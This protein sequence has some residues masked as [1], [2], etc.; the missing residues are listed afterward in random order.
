M[1]TPQ[2]KV[3]L[4]D[5]G[6]ASV[7]PSG[8]TGGAFWGLTPGYAAPEQERGE[9]TTTQTDLYNL[10]VTLSCLLAGQHSPEN[11]T[12][13]PFTP[14]ETI[15]PAA[16]RSL[17]TQMTEQDKNLRPGTAK[18]IGMR[19][20][21]ILTELQGRPC[22]NEQIRH[23]LAS[24][25]ATYRAS[26]KLET[27]YQ[28]QT[29]WYQFRL[30]TKQRQRLDVPAKITCIRS[31]PYGPDVEV[32]FVNPHISVKE[33]RWINPSHLWKL[34]AN[35]EE[36]G[37]P[38]DGFAYP[39]Q[40]AEGFEAVY[41]L[42]HDV[43]TEVYRASILRGAPIGY[44]NQAILDAASLL[45]ASQYREQRQASVPNF[46]DDDQRFDAAWA[47]GYA[48]ATLAEQDTY[49]SCPEGYRAELQQREALPLPAARVVDADSVRVGDEK[50]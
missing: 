33:Q 4:I 35:A 45:A 17:L 7:L 5:F 26:G 10:G 49:L 28:G 20:R 38:G 11:A 39:T 19:F 43:A 48:V 16:L 50:G 46:T 27:C 12:S 22:S 15:Q 29:V 3:V 21:E 8:K 30:P 41:L 31:Q 32:T 24:P 34:S 40:T 23:L 18:R 25:S 6:I 9:W 37:R 42:G 44:Q 13:E 36:E 1:V 47:A 2:G 14:P